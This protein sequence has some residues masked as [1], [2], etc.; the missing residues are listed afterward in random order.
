MPQYRVYLK[1]ISDHSHEDPR[2]GTIKEI[3]HTAVNE[4]HMLEALLYE[5]RRQCPDP[6]QHYSWTIEEISG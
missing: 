4:Q 1:N 3:V 6:H 2:P 5:I